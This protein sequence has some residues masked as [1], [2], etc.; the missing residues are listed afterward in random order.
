MATN[1]R[2]ADVPSSA[3]GFKQYMC[4][5]LEAQLAI[6]E[7][8]QC[9]AVLTTVATIYLLYQMQR[10]IS[11]YLKQQA[12]P[13]GLLTISALFKTS[14]LAFRPPDVLFMITHHDGSSTSSYGVLEGPQ[15]E[16]MHRLVIKIGRR[17]LVQRVCRD[18]WR[19]AF[20]LLLYVKRVDKSVGC[21]LDDHAHDSTY[22][23][24]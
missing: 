14:G 16:F 24:R 9:F 18:K 19:V 20:S 8:I 1:A 7:A 21:S 17:G 6:E 4:L 13:V 10:K 12:L 5:P 2:L 11:Q 22:R 3:L 23:S 15:V